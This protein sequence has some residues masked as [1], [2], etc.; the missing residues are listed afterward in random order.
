MA[1]RAP[2]Q[3]MPS[4]SADEYAA[5][6]ADIAA[7]GVQVPV[8]YDDRGNILDGHHRVQ[9]CGELGIVHWPKLVRYGLSEEEKRRHARRLNLDRR[10]LDQQQR[11]SL[12]E[13]EL[14]ERPEASD[15]LIA[16]GLGV[17]HKTVSKA[18]SDLESTGEIPQLEARHGR[19]QR[20]RRIVQFVPSTPEEEKGISISARAIRAREQERKVGIVRALRDIKAPQGG[21]IDDLHAASA[22]GFRACTI[23]AD[24][25]WKFLTRSAL[26][27]DRSACTHYKTDAWDQIMSLP[28]GQ[29]AAPN[30]TLFMW[31]VDWIPPSAI[32]EVLHVWGFEYKTV[33]FTWAKQNQGGEG[34]HMGMG[35]W[36]RSNPEQCILATKGSPKRLAADV[37][38]LV[39]AP[40]MEHS[41]KPDEVHDRI[42]RLVGGPYLEL[43]ARRERQNWVTWGNELQWQQPSIGKPVGLRPLIRSGEGE[44]E[45][46]P[47]FTAGSPMDDSELDI[48]DGLKRDAN[49]RASFHQNTGALPPLCD[50]EAPVNSAVE[51][52]T[53]PAAFSSSQEA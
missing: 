16:S 38:Q 30:S 10:H 25:P 39:V 33:A 2:Y 23:L 27:E 3:V 17:D 18:R 21:T 49:N 35:Y 28:V 41:R 45:S 44:P 31:I 29:L 32:D 14:R 7:R 15:R 12:I 40:V 9:I 52:E 5:L 34:W 6:K 42:E 8:E 47:G 53:A 20:K 22:S 46:D 1:D 19:D 26:G 4:L 48:P 51:S 36:T 11:R 37:R 50:R 24:P 43:Y 13:D